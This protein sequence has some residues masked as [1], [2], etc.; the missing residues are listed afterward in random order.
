MGASAVAAVIIRKEKDLVAHFERA[1]AV[2]AASA[3]SPAEL[4]VHEQLAWKRLL[5]RAVIRAAAPGTYYLD[6]PSWEALRRTRRRM[7]LVLG[8]LV[9]LAA[10]LPLL[11]TTGTYR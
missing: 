10:L 9:L 5:D 6:R 11:M 4:G 1:G 2:A 8:L 7:V 3:K